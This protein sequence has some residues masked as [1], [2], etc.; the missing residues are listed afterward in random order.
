MPIR[1]GTR[2]YIR[3]APNC[4]CLVHSARRCTGFSARRGRWVSKQHLQPNRLS[5]TTV[6]RLIAYIQQP[7]PVHPARQSIT[8][9]IDLLTWSSC[10]AP[11][12]WFCSGL[13]KDAAAAAL[14]RNSR[15]C[16]TALHHCRP[17]GSSLSQPKESA[18]QLS[19]SSNGMQTGYPTCT[20]VSYSFDKKKNAIHV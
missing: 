18:S 3:G 6:R 20:N 15:H 2:P 14:A 10:H 7:A 12:P 8:C 11:F 4:P 19:V 13:T 16:T 1:S 17:A 5:E 9:N